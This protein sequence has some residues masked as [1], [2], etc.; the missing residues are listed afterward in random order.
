MP[1]GVYDNTGGVREISIEGVVDAIHPYAARR[2][3]DP[4]PDALSASAGRIPVAEWR[5]P[6]KRVNE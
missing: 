4:P 2:G 6:G 3:E 5:F 1:Q